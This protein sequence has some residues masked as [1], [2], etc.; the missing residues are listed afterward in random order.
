M[1]DRVPAFTRTVQ[2]WYSHCSQPTNA[3]A[4]LLELCEL[5]SSGVHLRRDPVILHHRTVSYTFPQKSEWMKNALRGVDL[6][7]LHCRNGVFE[8]SFV[9]KRLQLPVRDC[10]QNGRR[11]ARCTIRFRPCFICEG[12][13]TMRL[14]NNRSS[15]CGMPHLERRMCYFQ[16]RDVFGWHLS[17]RDE[18]RRETNPRRTRV[19][20]S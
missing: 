12:Y 10:I 8:V 1:R 4:K 18:R 19:Q 9:D 16:R 11:I 5:C 20:S 6:E 17:F 2:Q 14:W 3:D 13:M 7:G 15:D